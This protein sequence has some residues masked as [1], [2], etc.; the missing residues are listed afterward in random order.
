MRR[1]SLLDW[2]ILLA[3]LPFILAGMWEEWGEP[4]L[5]APVELER[6]EASE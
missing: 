1:H 5:R 3:L 6:L 4:W 2:L